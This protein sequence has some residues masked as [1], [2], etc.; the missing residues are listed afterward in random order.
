RHPTS[1]VNAQR[2]EWSSLELDKRPAYLAFTRRTFIDGQIDESFWLPFLA[3]VHP[4][5]TAGVDHRRLG[6]DLLVL[7]N[8]PQSH[9]IERRGVD[10]IE[11]D[12]EILSEHNR[13]LKAK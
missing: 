10:I 3:E 8:V 6:A 9:I 1:G 7:V 11:P 4:L 12:R 2:S 13:A 5:W